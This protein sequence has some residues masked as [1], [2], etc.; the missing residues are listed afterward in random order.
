MKLMR[1]LLGLI[2]YGLTGMF[3]FMLMGLPWWAFFAAVGVL[4]V[5]SIIRKAVQKKR[6]HVRAGIDQRL[7]ELQHEYIP[8]YENRGWEAE[9][10]DLDK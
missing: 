10:V 3:M 7:A 9:V 8:G 2:F 5:G 1:A 4:L 6:R